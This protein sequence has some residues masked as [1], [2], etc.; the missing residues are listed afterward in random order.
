MST[1]TDLYAN[2]RDYLKVTFRATPQANNS[3][4]NVEERF[5]LRLTVENIAPDD[6]PFKNPKIHYRNIRATVQAT[7]FATPLDA[8]NRPVNSVTE[9][10]GQQ[11][12]TPGEQSSVTVNMRAL[13]NLG[14]LGDFL[15]GKER[16]AHV[17]VRA[18]IDQDAFLQIRK[19]ID[20]EVEIEPT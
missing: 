8:Q 13:K 11:V 14:D 15:G 9:Q 10:F 1:A 16:V 4:I 12:L 18:A 6:F 20:P 7:D 2:F 17:Q 5:T 19:A 3:V